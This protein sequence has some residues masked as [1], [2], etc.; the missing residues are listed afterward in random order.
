MLLDD[1]VCVILR[2]AVFGTVLACDRRQ[3][4]RQTHDDSI[5]HASIAS[6]SNKCFQKCPTV[7]HIIF[8]RQ[9]D[10]DVFSSFLSMPA[11]LIATLV[12]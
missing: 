11:V 1:V 6:R 4:D 9:D 8:Y 7:H 10:S 12:P 5:Y 2:L 3:M